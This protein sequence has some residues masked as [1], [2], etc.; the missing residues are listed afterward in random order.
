M[1]PR[2]SIVGMLSRNRWFG[3]DRLRRSS[4][5]I[6]IAV[7]LILSFFPQRYQAIVSLSPSDPKA[8]GLGDAMSQLGSGTNVFGSQAALDLT[9]KIGKSL[10]VRQAVIKKLDLTTRLDDSELQVIRWLGSNVQIGTLRGGIIQ[11]EMKN[12]DAALAQQ[13]VAVYAEAIRD[14][15][16]V[17]ARTQTTYK[18][19]VLEDLVEQSSG[20]LARAQATYDAYRR[21]AGYSDPRKALTD[22]GE[23]IPAL[24]QSIFEKQRQLDAYRQF[25]T[26]DNMQVRNVE[27]ELAALRRQLTEAQAARTGD[28]GSINNV[29]VGGTEAARL[30]RE[31]DISKDLYYSYQKFLQ[32]TTVEDRTSDA[33]MRILEP[34]YISPDRQINKVPFAVA[35]LIFL[36]AMAIEFYRFRP[37]VG[38]AK[39]A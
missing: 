21:N 22:V 15:L 8:L 3:N 18:R 7:C 2:L 27:A 13:I 23:R 26:R 5:A 16:A 11:I 9:V 12:S 28:R 36:L 32:G 34:A 37:P 29:I 1:R 35:I 19:Q 38:D 33:N 17:I 31:V 4:V 39:A 14:R 20:R 30:K 24:E 6:V 25:A 10:N